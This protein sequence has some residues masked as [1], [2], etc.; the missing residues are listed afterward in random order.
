MLLYTD[1]LTEARGLNDEEFGPDRLAQILV[2]H[3]NART[4]RALVQN[5]RE[6]LAKFLEGAHV[7]DDLTILAVQRSGLADH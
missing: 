5:I 6:N 2:Q 3:S 4:P 1:G 7:A